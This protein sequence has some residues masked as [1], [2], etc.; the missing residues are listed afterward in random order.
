MIINIEPNLYESA[1]DILDICKKILDINEII[2]DI[3]IKSLTIYKYD[4]EYYY[5]YKASEI[6]ELKFIDILD[7][8][9]N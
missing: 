4:D 5:H 7:K 3:N 6:N 8:E 1:E 2:D 9:I